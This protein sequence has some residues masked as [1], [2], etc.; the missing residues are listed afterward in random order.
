MVVQVHDKSL[1]T[2]IGKRFQI[3]DLVILDIGTS[4]QRTKLDVL[5]DDL[6]LVVKL[7][8]SD[9]VTQK[10]H[11]EQISFYLKQNVLIT[12]Q[13]R[14]TDIF[15]KA[16]SE[17]LTLVFALVTVLVQTRLNS[18]KAAS[19]DLRSTISSISCSTPSSTAT[20]T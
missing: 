2:S 6:F 5:D 11:I 17:S 13:Q 3:H 16:K 4:E 19:D 18:T 15:A 1:L 14:P 9:P 10:I 20:W 8:H 12:F 7:I